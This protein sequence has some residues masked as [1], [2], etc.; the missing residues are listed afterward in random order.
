MWMTAPRRLPALLA[1]FL[2]C[3]PTLCRAQNIDGTHTT[4]APQ[5]IDGPQTPPPTP[6][7]ASMN[8][9]SVLRMSRAGLGEDLILQTIAT[10][11]GQYTT[12]PD[13]LIELKQ[14]GLS[15]A[16]ITAMVNHGRIRIT[17][18]RPAPAE[19]PE[20]NEIGVYYKDNQGRWVAIEPEIVHIKTGGWLKSTATDGIIKQDHNGHVNGKESKLLLPRPIEFLIY[21]ADG[22]VAS[23]YEYLRFRLNS[24]SREF[25]ALTGG[26]FHSTG[27]AQRD[28]MPFAP[29]KTGP[30]TYTFTVGRDTPGG[31]YGIL[32]PGTGNITNGG[33]I[34]TFAISE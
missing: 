2:L 34:Y 13:T 27:G 22:V 12:D 1:L 11:P 32:P 31:E 25:R 17:P 14:S 3:A 6:K 10:Q 33:K 28:E 26:V 8:N 5:M 30:H 15:D 9:D 18:D 29:V 7:R 21:T 24:N 20:V 19:A 4:E 23:E 16:I